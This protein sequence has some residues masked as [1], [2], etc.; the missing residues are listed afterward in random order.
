MR[1]KRF[2]MFIFIFISLVFTSSSYGYWLTIEGVNQNE[3]Q[4]ALS[5]GSGDTVTTTVTVTD[6]TNTTQTLVPSAY[7]T[8]SAVSTISLTFPVDWASDDVI[9]VDGTAGT[10][11]VS[12]TEV[13]SIITGSPQLWTESGSLYG[14][15]FTITVSGAGPITIGTVI[16]VVLTIEF[17]NEPPNEATYNQVAGNDLEIDLDFSITVD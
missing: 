13:R 8:G 15:M 5:V 6:Q 2:V 12:I 11:V 1:Q 7:A 9:N 17:T 4:G 16:N 10:L 14:D 3:V